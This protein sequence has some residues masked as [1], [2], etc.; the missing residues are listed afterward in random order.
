MQTLTFD[1]PDLTRQ[2][3][4]DIRM[5]VAGTLYE[6]RLTSTAEAARLVGLPQREFIETMGRYG[7]SLFSG[8]PD[9][10]EQ[11]FRVELS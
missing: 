5:R 11:D 2:A 7:F 1:L 6:Q 10:Y 8:T 3:E 4:H 9:E